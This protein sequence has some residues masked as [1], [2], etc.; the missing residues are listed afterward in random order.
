M[1]FVFW[2]LCCV[3]VGYCANTQGRNGVLWG[4]ASVVFSPII[5]GIALA[6]MPK[7][8]V[9]NHR[10]SS[11]PA[12][13][14]SEDTADEEYR[15]YPVALPDESDEFD[16]CPCDDCGDFECEY[17]DQDF[18]KEDGCPKGGDI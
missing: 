5:V 2:L 8:P 12:N 9:I 6:V 4:I 7:A 15:P 1:A 16:E 11:P 18:I 3:F 14:K 10:S 13:R 17:R